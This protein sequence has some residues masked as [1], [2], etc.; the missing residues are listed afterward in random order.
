MPDLAEKIR[1]KI[2]AAF[3]ELDEFSS[4]RDETMDTIIRRVIAEQETVAGKCEHCLIIDHYWHKE[5]PRLPVH[6]GP[7]CGGKI[8]RL[9]DGGPNV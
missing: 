1:K 7:V 9:I 4:S 5:C 8:R 6:D 2:R 3:H